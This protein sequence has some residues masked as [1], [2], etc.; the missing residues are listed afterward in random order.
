MDAPRTSTRRVIAVITLLVLAAVALRGY[1]PG[2][3]PPAPDPPADDRRSSLLA[4]A[5]VL[6]LLCAAIA[7]IGLAIVVRLRSPQPARPPAGT[8][9][10][11]SGAKRP[12]WRFVVI[13][14]LAVIGWLLFVSVLNRI[15]DPVQPPS[16]PEATAPETPGPGVEDRTPDDPKPDDETPDPVN[17]LIPPMLV[18]MALIVIGSALASRQQGRTVAPAP[19]HDETDA[20]SPPRAPSLARAAEVGLA[21]IGDVSRE[22]REAII[23]CYAAMER[24]LT[25]VPG[26]APQAY[27][28]PTEVL[29]RAVDSGALRADSATDLVHLFEEARFSPH[30]MTEAHRDAAVEVLNRVLAELPRRAAEVGS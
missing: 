3:E 17:Y 21:A 7:V 8:L 23:A 15:V 22:P 5:A 9:P 14:L 13:A 28:T 20:A 30:V 26:A 2:V 1:L 19:A 12:S 25:R 10:R 16:P 4:L 6:V 27:D 29:A 11:A 18:L 24:E